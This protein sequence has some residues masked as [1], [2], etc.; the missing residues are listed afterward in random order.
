MTIP[1]SEIKEPLEVVLDIIPAPVRDTANRRK[2]S[3]SCLTSLRRVMRK[4]NRSR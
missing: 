2:W 3:R 4:Q 1:T